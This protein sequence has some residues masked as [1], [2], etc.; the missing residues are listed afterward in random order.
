MRICTHGDLLRKPDPGRKAR[1]R[2][3][4]V[5]V[6]KLADPYRGERQAYCY[7]TRGSI[8]DAEDQIHET[9]LRAWRGYGEFEGRSSLRTWL[10]RIATNAC[11]R[12]IETRGR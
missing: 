1:R 10:Y 3:G 12:A 2:P 4:T 8:D 5:D 7:R 9:L 6:E 11:L